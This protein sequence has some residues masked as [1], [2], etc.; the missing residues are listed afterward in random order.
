MISRAVMP[1]RRSRHLVFLWVAL[2][3][4]GILLQYGVALSTRHRPRGL[5]LKAATVQG[6]EIDGDLG[7]TRR[8]T[9][10]TSRRP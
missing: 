3:L 8:A 1:T 5:D 10:A 2:F 7:P 6:F 9:R 4:L